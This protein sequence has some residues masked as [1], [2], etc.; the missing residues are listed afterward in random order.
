MTLGECQVNVL[1]GNFRKLTFMYFQFSLYHNRLRC[2]SQVSLCND[3]RS[4]H[5]YQ[6]SKG[7]PMKESHAGLHLVRQG[8]FPVPN[9]NF[10]CRILPTYGLKLAQATH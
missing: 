5:I 1:Y 7:Q 4:D 8:Q 6:A 10:K 9:E 3:V 2:E